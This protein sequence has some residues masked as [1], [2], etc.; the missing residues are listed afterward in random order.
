[1]YEYD[2]PR[3]EPPKRFDEVLEYKKRKEFSTREVGLTHPD[4]SGFVRIAD[5]G[6][7]EIF[8]APGVGIVI[9]PGTRSISIFADSIKFFSK[10]DDGLRWNN[11]SFNP[12]SDTYNEPALIKTA[13]FSNNPAFFRTNYYLNNL[14]NLDELESEDS[15]TIIGDYGLGPGAIPAPKDEEQTTTITAEQEKL[16]QEYARVNPDSSVFMLRELIQYGYS[17]DQAIEKIESGDL[18]TSDNL[19]DFPWI[20]NDLD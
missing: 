5:S 2:L 11:M 14:D 18:N 3:E 17:F 20:F 16:I 4:N 7:V 19:E 8:A 12:A 1:M 10:E 13:D 15:I 9:N 6:E